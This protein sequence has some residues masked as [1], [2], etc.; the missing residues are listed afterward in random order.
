[1]HTVS[2]PVVSELH[3]LYAAADEGAITALLAKLAVEKSYVAKL[4]E[5]RQVRCHVAALV[6]RK[7]NAG[8]GAVV[9]KHVMSSPEL[10]AMRF[11]LHPSQR[12]AVSN[13]RK[14]SSPQTSPSIPSGS[15]CMA[16]RR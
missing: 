12:A 1:M 10:C 11:A 16:V 2:V 6:T 9:N 15:V 5:T 7:T 8:A 14:L 4:D 13:G 3:Q